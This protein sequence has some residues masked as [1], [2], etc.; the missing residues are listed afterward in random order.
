MAT[1]KANIIPIKSSN[2]SYPFQIV[3]YDEAFGGPKPNG[4]GSK[5][6]EGKSYYMVRTGDCFRTFSYDKRQQINIIGIN[7]GFEWEK[8][9]K[10]FIDFT[11][12]GNLQVSG[13]AF[14]KCEKVGRDSPGKGGKN[15]IDPGGWVDFPSMLRLIPE[16][17]VDDNGYIKKIADYKRQTKAYLLLGLRSDDAYYF[18]Q[19]QESGSITVI[20]KANSNLIMMASQHRGVPVAFPMPWHGNAHPS[21]VVIGSN[22]F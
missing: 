8:D 14:I 21:G 7:S 11:I 3:E 22:P 4:Y 2:I 5:G 19:N 16:D 10:V 1:Y 17:E 6:S 9:A 15:V 20:Q 12:L 13:N 18:N